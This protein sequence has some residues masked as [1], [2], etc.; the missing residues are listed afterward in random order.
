MFGKQVHD[1]WEPPDTARSRCLIDGIGAAQR[2]ENRAA[3]RRLRMV[4]RLFET[5]RAERGEEPDWA[6]DTWAAVG[7][8]IAAALR[9]S[10]GMAGSYLHQ[11]LAMLR[12]P[13]VAAVF[14]A[15]EIDLATYRAIVYR[16]A[17]VLDEDAVAE[18]DRQL[19]ARVPRWPSMTQGRLAREID[20]LVGEVD[21]DAVRRVRER[22]RDRDVTIWPADDGSADLSARLFVTDARLL[23]KK[24]DA[25]A[26]TVCEADPRTTAQR[27]ADSLG[28]MAAGAERLMC[29][30]GAD[31]CPAV[32]ATAA[33]V[34]IHVVAEQGTIEGTSER[35]GYVSDSGELIPAD[36]VREV[37]ASARLRPLG[38]PPR[39][40]EPGY[41]PSAGLAAFV[42]ARDLTCRA[43]GC[44][45]P[46]TDCDIDHTL[47]FGEGGATH[48]SNLKCLCRFHHLVKTFWGWRDRQLADG[49]V[50]WELPDGCAYVT[51]P[52]SAW[53]FPSLVAPTAEPPHAP[54]PPRAAD[55]D[56]TAMMPRRRRTRAQNRAH[57]IAAERSRNRCRREAR[58]AAIT[59]ALG[60]AGPAC[61]DE[62]PPPF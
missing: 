3:A 7:A 6:V 52:G 2:A 15:G 48:P 59:G 56:R 44:D 32:E 37:A 14:E 61:P 60:G 12:W 33:A 23:D 47:P 21:P 40:A 41:R 51:T 30:C 38:V 42:R 4:A 43:P 9:I 49:T 11:G 50:I 19:A 46:A 10:L 24:L 55:G 27:R 31:R 8:E 36:V 22:A 34:V 62:D 57:A 5:R 28:A 58:R 16:T 17:L 25:M 13:A 45:R 1:Y 18:I 53:L 54:R 20:R 29:R 26:A 39:D 35:P